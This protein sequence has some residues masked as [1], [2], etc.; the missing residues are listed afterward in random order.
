MRQ[1]ILSILTATLTTVG[2]VR[3]AYAADADKPPPQPNVVFITVETLR[4]DHVGCYGYKRPT[5]PAMDRLAADGLRFARCI[6]A[7]NWTIPAQMTMFTGVHPSIHHT[8]TVKHKLAPNLTT[9]AA[10]FKRAGYRTAGFTANTSTDGKFGF[11]RGFDHYDDFSVFMAA[12]LNLFGDRAEPKKFYQTVTSKTL[13]RVALKWLKKHADDEQPFFL[14]LF[15]YDPHFA[16]VPPPEYKRMFA[17]PDYDGKL[18][19]TNIWDLR[20]KDTPAEDQRHIQALY[21]GDVRYT[22]DHV[23]KLL[24]ALKQHGLYDDTI[25]LLVGDHGDEFWDHGSV[26]HGHTLYDELVH[27]PLIVRWP[28]VTTP[29]RVVD[30]QVCHLDVMST[31]LAMAGLPVPRQCMGRD[32]TP[33]LRGKDAP[34]TKGIAFL[35]GDAD[36][37]VRGLCTATRKIVRYRDTDELLFLDLEADPNERMNLAG[38]ARE[39][40]FAALLQVF[41]AWEERMKAARKQSPAPAKSIDP[42][43]RKRLK[44]LGYMQ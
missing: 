31:V 30:A 8:V 28:G 22:D 43:L 24:D 44:A 39:K 19:G 14:H 18:D 6:S 23:G 5:T 7:S 1:S 3:T 38:T 4:A 2:S 25:I 17:N 26:A 27:V 37:A 32:L 35:E 20:G 29:G 15:Y 33:V 16:Y 40:E 41:E 21:D 12:D 9:L 42:E 36:R 11:S 13:N 10:E 34:A